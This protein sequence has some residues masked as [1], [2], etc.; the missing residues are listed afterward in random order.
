MDPV[1]QFFLGIDWGTVTHVLCLLD[2]DGRKLADF[3]VS[4]NG[5]G[6][7]QLLSWLQR[8]TADAR[9]EQ[10]AAAIEMPTGAV[11]EMLAEHRYPVFAINPKQLDRFRDRHSVAGAKDDRRDAFV[12]ADSLRTDRHCFHA[13]DL[14]HPQIIRLRTLSRLRYDLLQDWS[15][16]TNQLQQQLLRYYPQMLELSPAAD[17]LWMWDLL[18]AAPLPVQVAGLKFQRVERILIRHRI[19]RISADQVLEKLRV[20]PLPVAPGTAE[21]AS[22]AALLFLARLRALNQQCKD[23]DRRIAE[24]LEQLQSD[25]QLPEHRDVQVLCSVKGVGV[26]VAATMLAE[27]FQP[28]RDRDYH[29]LRTY[30][31]AAPVT[32]QS[33]KRCQVVMRYGCNR[34]LRHALYHWARVSLVSDPRSRAQYHRLREHGHSHGRAL[35]GVADRLLAMLISM[36][37]HQTN[38]D[39]TLRLVPVWHAA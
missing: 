8:Q 19:R 14:K 25:G 35:R 31:G 1:F 13:V 39:P 17:D 15:R 2:K 23:V 12:L 10:V 3:Q 7:Q 6:L 32:R 30:A 9:P 27:A 34:P 26:V 37:K 20:T 33:G 28:L 18:E 16:L 5:P 29:A 11:V 21:S 38:Y 4:H 36:L 22:E 24:L